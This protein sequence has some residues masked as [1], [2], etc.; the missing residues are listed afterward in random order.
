MYALI[1]EDGNELKDVL[2]MQEVCLNYIK[3][4]IANV[5]KAYYTYFYNNNK[6]IHIDGIGEDEFRSYISSIKDAIDNH[7]ASKFSDEEFY[8]YRREYNPTESERKQMEDDPEYKALIDEEYD[9]AWTH[10]FMNNDHHPKFWKVINGKYSENNSPKDM[11]L[12]AIIHMICDWES[13]SMYYGTN[14]L[15]WYLNN[16]KEEKNDM[17]DKTKD[18]VE[19]ILRQIHGEFES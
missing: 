8:A 4:H 12:G 3:E 16:A 5:Q 13:V 6:P 14:T 18:I 15:E 9:K 11:S 2:H 17:S 10:H 19:Q 1:R 7:D